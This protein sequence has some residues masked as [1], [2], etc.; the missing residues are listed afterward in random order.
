M[1]RYKLIYMII[2]VLIQI[3]FINTNIS[4]STDN[5]TK[6]S[7]QTIP[8]GIYAIRTVLNETYG[9]DVSEAS[10]ENKA[11]IQLYEYRN[12]NQ[13]KFKVK[14]EG[15]GYYSIRIVRSGKS[16][17][18]A[19][20]GKENGTNVWQYE[21]NGTD[22]QKWI[23]KDVGDGTY[24]I[25]SKDNGL[26]L[27]VSGE[28]K[29]G[30]NIHMYS[31]NGTEKQKFKFEKATTTAI[32][33]EQTIPNGTYAIK[34]VLNDKYGLDV[35]QASK[36]NQ[37]NIQL[38]E[39]RNVRQ[40]KFNVR[41][42][43]DG[44]Y[45]ITAVHSGKS[46]DVAWAGT[47]E[48]TNIW[49][50]ELNGTDAQKWIIHDAGDGTYNIISK[51]NG[52]YLS[53][54]N[55]DV[56]NET[57]I[58]MKSK[59]DT[60]TQKFKF[61][62]IKNTINIDTNKY[63][64][65]KE[66]IEALMEKH[67]KWKFELLYTGLTFE[68]V[69]NGETSLHSRNLVP[70]N[71]GGEWICL[72]CGI[73]LYDSG[74]YCASEKAVAYYMDP[75]NFLDETNIFQFQNLN[76]YINGVCTLEGIKSQINGTYLQD[77]ASVIDNA[78]KNQ[79]VNSYYIITR[80]IQ[81]QGREGTSIGKGMDGG[82]GHTYYNPFNIDASGNGWDQIYSNALATAKKYGWNTM[83]KAIEGGIEFCKKNWLENYQNTLYQN[84]FDIDSRNGTPLY[85]HQY[86]QNLMG[87]YSE[88]RLMKG[89]YVDTNKLESE[90]TF[91]I[92]VYENMSS[93]ISKM[94]VN[95]SNLES[96]N[97]KVATTAGLNLR[98]GASTNYRII[99][100]IYGNEELLSVERGINGDWHK[101]ITKDG[102]IGYMS[103]LY[104][105]Q[106]NNITNCDYIAKVKTNDGNGCNVRVGPSIRLNKITALPDGTTVRVINKGTYNNIDGYD[107]C[108]IELPDGR[109]AFIPTKYL[110]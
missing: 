106:I 54:L 6:E 20:A 7:E 42:Q 95:N 99:R 36:Q 108:R 1:K 78:C 4:F 28:A 41:F 67:P 83:Q 3:L 17:D 80:M 11:N 107:W 60:N 75:R 53:V 92:P 100:T 84:K 37:A 61:E 68:E 66:K 2:F 27:E 71:Y 32:L 43:G 102:T 51:S 110:T 70:T 45:L 72:K 63:P 47:E 79:N 59:K 26:Y 65:Y 25:I 89:M 81:E 96:I 29:N 82:D 15:D 103:G 93:T 88:A 55:E 13:Q 86:M 64:G 76:G 9:L 104:L 30:T 87:A 85:Q 58:L 62:E 49:Q 40:Q 94:P 91:I 5:N 34:T 46:L 21:L 101:I 35:S 56:K 19:W 10:K 98:E 22:A 90:F 105:K 97:V 109:H 33:G 31:R 48:G 50:Y 74:W 52:L 39:Y 24:N 23:I 16:L 8:D 57:N 12:V 38:Y 69:I 18:V 44:N 77:Y 14:Y 73:T